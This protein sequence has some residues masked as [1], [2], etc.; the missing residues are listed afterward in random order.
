[1]PR[2]AVVFSGYWTTMTDVKDYYYT[3]ISMPGEFI[4]DY[5]YIEY[6]D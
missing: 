6:Y 4:I 3:S 5:E 1:M 2:G